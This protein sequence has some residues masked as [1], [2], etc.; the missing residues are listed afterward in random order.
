M[1]ARPFDDMVAIGRVVKPQG[2][3][4]EVVVEPFSDR[5]DR[6][7]ALQTVNVPGE[8]GAVRALAV[9]SCW[10]HKGRFVLKLAGID[11]ITAAETLRG[12]E[13]RIGE[14]E[15]AAL[16]AG[17]YYHHQ[18]KGLEVVDESGASLGTVQE[19]LETGG[20]APV[21][22]VRNH[23][24]ETLIPLAEAFV[25]QVDLASGRITVVRPQYAEAAR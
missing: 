20:E 11:S 5:P 24:A 10:P 6:F 4:G 15:L 19:I 2:R 18:L 7:P 16:P 23:G 13:V 22:S 9:E 14:E 3:K 17:S 12:L 1:A 8:G 21:L 25:R